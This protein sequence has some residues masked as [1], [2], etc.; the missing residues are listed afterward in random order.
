MAMINSFKVVS[1][2]DSIVLADYFKLLH[3]KM[4]GAV[5]RAVNIQALVGV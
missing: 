5:D 3:G 1:L 2:I 4:G